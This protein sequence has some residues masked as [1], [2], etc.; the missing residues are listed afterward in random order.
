L[1]ENLSVND[2]LIQAYILVSKVGFSYLD[3]KTMN[4]LERL[5]FIKF[6][7]DEITRESQ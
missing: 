2:L 4:R 5:A 1:S 3:V 6:Y 7:K